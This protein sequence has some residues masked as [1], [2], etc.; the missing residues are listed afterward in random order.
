MHKWHEP[1]F[2]RDIIIADLNCRHRGKISI[3]RAQFFSA[4][5]LQRAYQIFL[6]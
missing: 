6:R 1:L 2:C 5:H 4:I 3:H